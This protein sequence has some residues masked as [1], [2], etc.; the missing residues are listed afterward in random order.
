MATIRQIIDAIKTQ[1]DTIDGLKVYKRVPDTVDSPA[2][3]I[4]YAGTNYDS[5][6][7]RGSDDQ[8]YVVQILTSKA[9][10]RGQDLL[11]DYCEGSGSRSIKVAI[12]ADST[13]G[14]RVMSAFVTETGEPGTAE[15]G[16]VEFYSVEIFIQVCLEP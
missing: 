2:A 3:V 4:R 7:A 1:L 15:P 13:L 12:E 10:D 5:T 14:D 6:M 16:G 11:Y 9:S 8:T